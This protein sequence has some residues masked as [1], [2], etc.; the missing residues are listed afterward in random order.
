MYS[1][2]SVETKLQI[3]TFIEENVKRGDISKMVNLT[4]DWKTFCIEARNEYRGNMRLDQDGNQ[5]VG[6]DIYG[7]ASYEL[8]GEVKGNSFIGEWKNKGGNIN[9]P[10]AFTIKNEGRKL[11]GIYED[12]GKRLNCTADRF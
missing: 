10:F 11:E 1:K 9:S 7:E 4:G 2:I 12:R 3:T 5:V 8:I 6:E